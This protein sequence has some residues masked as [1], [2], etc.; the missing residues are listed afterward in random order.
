M[1]DLMRLKVILRVL[2]ELERL[3]LAT[4]YSTVEYLDKT[5]MWYTSFLWKQ[6]SSILPYDIIK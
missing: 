6:L 3:R 5:W 4:F 2:S 1:Q